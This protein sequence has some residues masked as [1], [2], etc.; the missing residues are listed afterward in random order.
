MFQAGF[1]TNLWNTDVR[2]ATCRKA[3]ASAM[4]IFPLDL[5]ETEKRKFYK[6]SALPMNESYCFSIEQQV[7]KEP[8]SRLLF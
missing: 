3:S 8:S 1:G 2:E 7:A 5:L 4:L 6:M